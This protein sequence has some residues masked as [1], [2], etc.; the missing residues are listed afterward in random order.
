MGLN[1]ALRPRHRPTA[2]IALIRSAVELGVTFFDTA[3]AYGPFTNEELVGEALAPLR[4]RVVIAT[5][6]ASRMVCPGRVSTAVRSASRAVAEA[7]LERLKTDRIDLFYQ[8]TRRSERAHRRR[9]RH[10]SGLVREGKVGTSG[11]PKQERRPS[12]V[13]PQSGRHRASGE[14][15]MW[16]REPERRS[17]HP[18]RTRHRLRGL[19]PAR[20]RF[21]DGHDRRDDDHREGD[22]S[23]L[24]A[25]RPKRAKTAPGA[26][27]RLASIAGSSA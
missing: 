19:Q 18:G 14:Y 17:S 15:S 1:F 9:G 23:L 12:A 24:R 10:P 25:S 13:R 4:D 20:Q 22:W 5:S 7:S 11:S 3:G 16:W 8:H 27:R 21:P 2:A 6:L 26:R